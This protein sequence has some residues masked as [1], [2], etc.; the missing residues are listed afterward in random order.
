MSWRALLAAASIVT[1]CTDAD[2]RVD[3][4]ATAIEI[5]TQVDPSAGVTQIR[6]SD[7]GKL[8]SFATGA[9]PEQP[10]ALA[11]EQSMVVL[12][13]D[14]LDGSE[15][16]VRID[17][18]AGD[19]IVSSGGARV[20]V[21]SA[22]V[23]RV[24]IALGP[25]AVCGDGKTN[26]PIEACDD[27]NPEVGDGCSGCFVEPGFVC[28]N[29]PQGVSTCR[30]DTFDVVSAAATGNGK[31]TVTFSDPP[32]PAAA[33]TLANYSIPG[34]DPSG[35]P[36]L[37]GNQVTITTS[38]QS[39]IDY[40]IIVSGITR[41]KD[42]KPLGV[43][44]AAFTGRTAFAVESARSTS[45]QQITV[46]FTAPPSVAE[47]TTLANYSVAGLTV[48]GT[49]TLA[50]STVTLATS[51]QVA[52]TYTVT[53]ANVTRA[54]DGESLGDTAA[55]FTGVNGFDVA[56][57]A[58]TSNREITVAFNAPPDPTQAT[59]LSNYT[60][61]GLALSGVPKLV[62]S[63]VTIVTA[64]QIVMPYTVTV[65][66]V[67]RAGDAQPLT[68]A[69]ATFV[70]LPI[71]DPTVTTVSVLSTNPNNGTTPYNTG[72]VTVRLTGTQLFTVVC[73]TGVKLDDLDG[74]GGAAATKPTSCTV[75][76]DTQITAT[77]PAGIRTNGDVGWNVQ[78]TNSV[79][80]NATSDKLVI[81]AGL[82][83][84]EPFV[85]TVA[86]HEFVELY[87]PTATAL[88]A[89]A[90]GLRLHVRSALG[91]DTNKALTFIHT[92]VASHGFMMLA[93]AQ[94]TAADP[95]FA[96]RDATYV[97]GAGGVVENGGVYLSL[98]TN[99]NQLVIDE[100]GWGNQ[101]MGGFEGAAL[102][103]ISAG[104]SAER[105]PAGGAGHATDTDDN[106]A[107]FN[108]PSTTITP[109]GTA[110]GPQP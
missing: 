11:G 52:M 74:A 79:G 32:E 75:D 7:A 91:T 20:T 110:D 9:L 63:S 60:V 82:L 89:S 56:S 83:I 64:A 23:Q 35:V 57:A 2:T 100:V 90:I 71:T 66:G 17:G 69:A 25:P 58:S 5:V 22:H 55:S 72:T 95:W 10:R 62:G 29:P 31:V 12:L 51:N 30:V 33:T 54:I 28:T 80:T 27:A 47:A 1:A 92:T 19:T 36:F 39:A 40:N 103:N 34:L 14:S 107:D 41:A 105:K 46:T 50:G 42:A 26:D 68:N 6:I 45:A 76:S 81:R 3:E 94:S 99:A 65:A 102:V 16:V 53:V 8:P 93:S 13:P 87:N 108:P 38:S 4:G 106:S 109:L 43:T 44:V 97:V 96:K 73:A 86:G 15:L 104:Q 84:S 59:T 101:P 98:R 88:D 70:G 37:A 77:F 49:P 85:G 21:R 61:P 24:D 67:T 78:A 18:L 48:T